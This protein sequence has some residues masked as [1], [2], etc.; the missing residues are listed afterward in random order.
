MK[1]SVLIT[2]PISKAMNFSEAN[3][4]KLEKA[5]PDAIISVHDNPK[6]FREDLKEIDIVLVWFFNSNWIKKAPNLKWVATPAAGK[7][8]LTTDFPEHILLTHS[9]FHGEIIAENVLGAMLGFSRGLFWIYKHQ[10]EFH[11]PKQEYDNRVKA[12]KGTHLVI[13]GYGHIGNH[14]ARLAKSF[15]VQIT[16]I[17]RNLIELPKFFDENDKIN[18]IEDLDSVLPKTDHLV[19]TLPRDDSTDNIINVERLKLLPKN[20]FIYNVG[21][22]NT[23][24][25]TALVDALNEGTISGAYLDVFQKEPIEKNS[26]LRN[27]PNL[28]LTPHSSAMAP[29]FLDLFIDEFVEKYKQW[30]NKMV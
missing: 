28:L 5:L 4:N 23:I 25:E 6:S 29:N 9:S 1:I 3:K 19:L 21:R 15:G 11:W 17:K 16:G 26:P 20:A 12:L 24:D 18:T 10:D 27:C 2:N 13:L 22:G 30:K 14:I 8:Y 7:D